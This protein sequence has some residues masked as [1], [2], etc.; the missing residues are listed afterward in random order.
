MELLPSAYYEN[1]RRF[2]RRRRYQRLS[3]PT[4]SRK[5][6]KIAR[7]GGR[8]PRRA[9]PR[10]RLKLVSPVRLLA[11]FHEV[12]VRMMIQLAQNL[13][14]SKGPR[15]LRGK[16]DKKCE[17]VHVV[18]AGEEVDGRLVVEYYNRLMAA[19]EFALC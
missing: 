2:L 17:P 18:S 4:N 14:S 1:L 11:K 19:R 8:G 6:L 5:R 9:P 12:Y 3:S 13:G 10:L 16:R 7:L 15:V